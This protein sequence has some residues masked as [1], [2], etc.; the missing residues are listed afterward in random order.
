MACTL[1][2]ALALRLVKLVGN[3]YSRNHSCLT[4]QRSDTDSF[5]FLHSRL[6][7]VKRVQILRGHVKKKFRLL[8]WI[9]DMQYVY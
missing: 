8:N 4:L 3:L 5:P 9:M 7:L 2:L 6:V 1:W